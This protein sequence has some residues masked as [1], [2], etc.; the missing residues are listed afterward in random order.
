MA[1][2]GISRYLS[3]GGEGGSVVY[4]KIDLVPIVPGTVVI[5]CV[6]FFLIFLDIVFE[7]LEEVSIRNH[8]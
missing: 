8:S 3:G 5:L 6:L 4:G 1:N 7:Y 2:G